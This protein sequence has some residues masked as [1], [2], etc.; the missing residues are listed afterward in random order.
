MLLWAP[1]T[2]EGAASEAGVE[3]AA[4]SGLGWLYLLPN[5][6]VTT[7]PH[8]P[9]RIP[10]PSIVGTRIRWWQC[11]QDSDDQWECECVAN[12]QSSSP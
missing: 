6:T 1:G 2:H 8:L 9:Q 3:S 12:P 5:P 7:V 11:L 4:A 10:G